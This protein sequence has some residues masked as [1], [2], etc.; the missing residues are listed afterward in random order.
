MDMFTEQQ[1]DSYKY[2]DAVDTHIPFGGASA[3]H[4]GLVVFVPSREG[5]A[6]EPGHQHQRESPQPVYIKWKGNRNSNSSNINCA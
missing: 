1:N 4:K 6:D 2:P 3:C 5:D